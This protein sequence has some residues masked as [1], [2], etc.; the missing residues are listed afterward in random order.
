MFRGAALLPERE[1]AL[2]GE[3][4]TSLRGV[5]NGAHLRR[6]RPA[7]AV[8]H[9]F[10][11]GRP[12]GHEDQGDAFPRLDKPHC[13]RHTRRCR[14]QSSPTVDLTLLQCIQRAVSRRLAWAPNS[15]LRHPANP[16]AGSQP[17]QRSIAMLRERC[18]PPA[19]A[20]SDEWLPH[21]PS[22][23]TPVPTTRAVT[24]PDPPCPMP[25]SNAYAATTRRTPRALLV[26]TRWRV[27]VD[28][29]TVE[30]T[31]QGIDRSLHQLRLA[32]GAIFHRPRSASCA[33][34]PVESYACTLLPSLPPAADSITFPPAHPHSD[35]SITK[36]VA[37]PC[38]PI[39]D[40]GVLALL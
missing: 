34:A 10:A 32:S 14:P 11:A 7:R 15:I 21:L 24:A 25:R 30:P 31:G 23:P 28:R 38:R 18:R 16:L 26:S 6:Y 19:S 12:V 3:V 35:C 39:R 27:A 9:S 4:R 5:I 20:L 37:A 40:A 29:A 22:R 1:A 36:N 2:L 13:L 8:A 17:A 33:A